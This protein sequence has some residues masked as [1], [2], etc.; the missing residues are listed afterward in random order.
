MNRRVRGLL[1]IGGRTS[2]GVRDVVGER[3]FTAV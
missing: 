3:G 1:V 2:R